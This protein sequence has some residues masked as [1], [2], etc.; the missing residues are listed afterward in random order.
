MIKSVSIILGKLRARKLKKAKIWGKIIEI[1]VSD[2]EKPKNIAN[3]DLPNFGIQ[4]DRR[5]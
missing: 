4:E 2:T 1:K 3:A 5:V